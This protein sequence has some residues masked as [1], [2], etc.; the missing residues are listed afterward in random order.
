MPQLM[1]L[2]WIFSSMMMVMI[3]LMVC[4]LFSEEMNLFSAVK[5]NSMKNLLIKNLWFW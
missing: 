4:I 5:M 1:P 2:K 3:L